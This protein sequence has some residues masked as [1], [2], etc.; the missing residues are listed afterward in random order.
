MDTRDLLVAGVPISISSKY[1]YLYL[2]LSGSTPD[3][4]SLPV[5]ADPP[6]HV[7]SDACWEANTPCKNIT[8]AQTSFAGGNKRPPNSKQELL[9]SFYRKVCFGHKMIHAKTAHNFR[10]T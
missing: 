8:F 1:L 3:A 4:D 10:L 6:G 9:I 5:D 7:T 2:E